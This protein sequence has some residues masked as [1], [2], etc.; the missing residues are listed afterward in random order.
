MLQSN[1]IKD[2]VYI[3]FFVLFHVDLRF[4]ILETSLPVYDAISV[5]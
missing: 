3:F 5:R 2:F 1:I 4:N